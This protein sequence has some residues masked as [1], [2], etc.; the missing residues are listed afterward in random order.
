MEFEGIVGELG[1]YVS[2]L[3]DVCHEVTASEVREENATGFLDLHAHTRHDGKVFV[4]FHFKFG[5]SNND[6]ESASQHNGDID[7]F[8]IIDFFPG[9]DDG[10]TFL[11]KVVHDGVFPFKGRE[12]CIGCI[13]SSDK[14]SFQNHNSAQ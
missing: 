8:C 11:V 3:I 1:M 14:I 6:V 2:T 13:V 9:M 5:A 4:G 7:V 12:E 10:V